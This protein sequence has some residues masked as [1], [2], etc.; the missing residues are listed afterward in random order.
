MVIRGLSNIQ[1]KAR[2]RTRGIGITSKVYKTPIFSDR[3]G[4]INKKTLTTGLMNKNRSN[5][6]QCVA[7]LEEVLNKQEVN[8]RGNEET[9]FNLEVE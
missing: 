5:V 7:D 6:S 3:G 8:T 2:P 9:N 1:T 4:V